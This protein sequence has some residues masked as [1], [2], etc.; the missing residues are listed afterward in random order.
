MVTAL[1]QLGLRDA[2]DL[3]VGTSAGA[4]N[5]AWFL[6]GRPGFGT[7]LY[8]QDLIS[9]EW[10]DYRRILRRQPIIGL[11]YLMDTLMTEVKELD[12]D[13]VFA[14]GIPL[15]SVAARLPD[16]DISVLSGFESGEDLRDAL[17]ASA[18]I[19]VASGGPVEIDG[20]QLVDGSMASS[21][22]AETAV[23]TFGAT[24]VV[25]LLTRPVGEL[26]GKPTLAQRR[27]LFPLMNRMLPGLGDATAR[28]APRYAAELEY[29]NRLENSLIVQLPA[30]SP[31]VRQLD[32]NPNALFEAAAAGAAEVYRTFTGS[33]RRFYPGLTPYPGQ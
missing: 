23:R 17:R 4:M 32:Q 21:I 20:A 18:R 9:K 10:V 19:P 11:D 14:S 6:S 22:P 1:D 28:R 25:A 2:F 27:I 12:A 7:S 26:R 29:L 24:H 8:Y 15:Y 33:V 16:Y 3:V 13:A 5:G 30:G 31:P